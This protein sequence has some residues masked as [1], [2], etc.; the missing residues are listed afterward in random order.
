MG[1]G[2]RSK[3]PQLG[4]WDGGGKHRG[5]LFGFAHHVHNDSSLSKTL[6]VW[7]PVVPN[8]PALGNVPS[9]PPEATLSLSRNRTAV[10]KA[11]ARKP[12]AQI[13]WTPEGVDCV[14]EQEYWGNGTV[15]VQTSGES[16]MIE[17]ARV[18]CSHWA[19]L[20]GWGMER[21][22]GRITLYKIVDKIRCFMNEK[23]L[24]NN[25]FSFIVLLLC[26]CPVN[27]S[28]SV[29]MDTNAVLHCPRT[30]TRVV[31]TRWEIILR[32]KPSCTKAHRSDTNETK[33]INCTD[34]RITW[35]SRPSQ[36]PDLQ[37]APVAI[38]HDG[39]YRCVMV[40]PD[41][42]FNHN[43]HLQ[44]LVP[45]EATLSLSRNRTAVCKAVAGKPAAQISWTP[46]G[47]DCVT[48]Q[49]YWG[50]GTVTVQSTCSWE[51]P[52]VTTVACSVSHLTGNRSLCIELLPGTKT[53]AKLNI[54]CVVII[55]VILILIIMGSFWFLKISGCRKYK[56]NKTEAT[57][58]LRK[59][60]MKSYVSYSEKSNPLYDTANKVKMF[61]A[62]QS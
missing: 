52:D 20:P 19:H 24:I 34:D 62:L 38:T 8:F 26:V 58:V 42:N 33:E 12:A 14:T 17:P 23:S 31:L 40:T 50:N 1:Q 41:G 28:L 21:G 60:V 43:Y 39:Y 35:A 53:L 15:T 55:L 27:T 59:D 61:Q 11:V 16:S 2:K 29:V 36:N 7:Y 18:K 44:V 45:P 56:L 32:D 4:P 5:S 3:R 22:G 49:E 51:V 13:S 6:G 9:V 25:L 30:L 47:D 37:I 46:E 48:E 57:P 54:L 10:C